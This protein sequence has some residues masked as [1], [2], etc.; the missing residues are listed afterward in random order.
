MNSDQQ[1]LINV[2]TVFLI[3]PF[4]TCKAS[5]VLPCLNINLELLIIGCNQARYVSWGTRLECLPFLGPSP[6]SLGKGWV[7]STW[8]QMEWY[9]FLYVIQVLHNKG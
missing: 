7:G 2:A 4:T 1:L 5:S 6:A 8:W 3:K 9:G